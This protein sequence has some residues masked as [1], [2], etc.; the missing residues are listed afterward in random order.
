MADLQAVTDDSFETDVLKSDKPVL[1][2]FWA[3]WCGP[4]RQIAPILD[5]LNTAHGDKIAFV[6]MNVD[7]N[8]VTPASYRVTGIPN[9]TVFHNGE[10]VKQIVGSRPKSAHPQGARRVHRLTHPARRAQRRSSDRPSGGRPDARSR[11]T[12]V[13]VSRR[14]VRPCGPPPASAGAPSSP[15]AAGGRRCPTGHRAPPRFRL[16]DR[17]AVV[18][19]IRDLLACSTSLDDDAAASDEYDERVELAVRAFQQQRGLTVDGIVGASTYRR[20]DEARWRLGDR[21]LDHRPATCMAGDD[22]FALQQRLLDLGLQGRPRRRLLRPRDRGRRCGSSSATSAC[23]PT[24]PAARPRSRRSAG[25]RRA[26]AAAR[27]NAMRA[28]ERIRTRRPAAGRQ[29]RRD[30]PARHGG[31]DRDPRRPRGA[32]PADRARRGPPDR[33]PA[34]RDRRPGLPLR[35]APASR[36][37]R[38]AGADFANR[39]DADLT[40]SLTVDALPDPAPAASRRTSSA[41]RPTAP[42]PRP[43]SASPAWSSARSWPAP[44]WSTCGSHAKTWDFLRQ[45]RM[46]AVRLDLGYLTNAGDAVRL[47]RPE[48]RDNVAEAVVVADPAPLPRPRGRPAHRRAP[49]DQIRALRHLPDPDRGALAVHRGAPAPEAA[50]RQA[51]EAW[52]PSR[53]PPS[54]RV[55]CA[56]HASPGSGA[57]RR[58][59]RSTRLDGP[60]RLSASSLLDDQSRCDDQRAWCWAPGPGARA[61]RQAVERGLELLAPGEHRAQVHPHP[62]VAGGAAVG[63]E[64][65]PRAGSRP[66]A[67]RASPGGRLA[68]RSPNAS[69]ARMPP[70][71]TRSLAIDLHQHPA[72]AAAVVSRRR[73][74]PARAGR[75]RR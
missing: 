68:R 65:D 12:W 9:L 66:A 69:T 52:R 37:T 13:E 31:S 1:V 29:G 39:T 18:S 6:K 35:H 75:R 32:R 27:P 5:E 19:E 3:E 58:A 46:P 34:G 54:P 25:S 10:V 7:E 40:I 23:P 55:R 45:T 67:R 61:E 56:R 21:V 42:A 60:S 11:G 15:T 62:R 57:V 14:T 28:Q 48:F 41:P 51:K 47:G 63:P 74:A 2:D 53:V 17:G 49:H 36:T 71:L 16:G 38:H 20:L 50:A 44:T 8:P 4:C 43:A 73:P 33:G 59:R 30:R 22:V 64:A 70:R 24:A 72:E 26:S